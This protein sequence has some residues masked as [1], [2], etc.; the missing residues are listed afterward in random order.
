MSVLMG[1][2]L[3]TCPAAHLS[4]A[5]VVCS[6]S[7]INRPPVDS[8]NSDEMKASSRNYEK[9]MRLLQVQKM[10]DL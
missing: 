7:F 4:L 1:A 2:E 9:Q 5:G 10:F 3:L 6:S 8:S